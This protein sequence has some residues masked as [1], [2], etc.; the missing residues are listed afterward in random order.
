M[1]FCP[2][3]LTLAWPFWQ[4]VSRRVVDFDRKD[5]PKCEFAVHDVFTVDILVSTGDG[6][7]KDKDTRT[8]VY[9]KTENA[10]SLKM[11]AS[12][13]MQTLKKKLCNTG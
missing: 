5:H 10:Y 9:K 1:S 7:T 8:T 11:K 6:K 12:R 13:G 3:L 2:F 4:N